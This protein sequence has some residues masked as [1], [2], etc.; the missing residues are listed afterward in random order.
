M[1]LLAD[2]IESASRTLEDPSP[3]S[4]RG[5]I[6]RIIEQRQQ[7]GQFA[8]SPLNFADLEVIA[9]TFERMLTAVLHRRISYPSSEE[10]KGLKVARGLQDGRDTGPVPAPPGEDGEGGRVPKEVKGGRRGDRRDR[11]VPSRS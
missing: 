8:E 1:L 5:L 7:D 2:S 3:S 4:I 9:N 11:T 6:D 10:I